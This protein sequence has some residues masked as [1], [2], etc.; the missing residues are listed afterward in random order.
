MGAA[1][2]LPGLFFLKKVSLWAP[3]FHWLNGGLCPFG[4]GF[5]YIAPQRGTGITLRKYS[6]MNEK[7]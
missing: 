1:L 3:D 4:N 5:L 6:I 7:F 2:N